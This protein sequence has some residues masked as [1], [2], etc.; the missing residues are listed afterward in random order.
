[1]TDKNELVNNVKNWISI[2]NDIKELQKVIKEKRKEKKV[3]T[4]KLVDIM[5]SNDIDCFDM[6][7]GKL[8]YSRRTVKAALSKKHL[9]TSLSQYFKNNKD[10]IDELGQFILDS[11][12][13][14]IR[15]NI[16]RK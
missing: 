15:E 14:K 16:K 3:Y 8:V 6:K 10:I 12:A 11:R 1:M 4:E 9:F 13:E 5:K 7:S 2:D